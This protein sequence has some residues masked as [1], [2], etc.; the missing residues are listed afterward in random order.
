MTKIALCS[1]LAFSTVFGSLAGKISR[2][3]TTTGIDGDLLGAAQ[4]TCTNARSEDVG[5][6]IEINANKAGNSDMSGTGIYFRM[7]NYIV[8]ADGTAFFKCKGQNES[9][10]Q[11]FS[12]SYV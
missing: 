8:S 11:I 4:V 6:T 3:K 2:V 12:Y 10:K 7:K 9:Y 1:I 5:N